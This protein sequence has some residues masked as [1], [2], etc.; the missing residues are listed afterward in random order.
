M[1]IF[2]LQMA[3]PC[4]LTCPAFAVH[5]QCNRELLTVQ[6]TPTEYL[7][8]QGLVALAMV[9]PTSPEIISELATCKLHNADTVASIL[10]V[11]VFGKC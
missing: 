11:K 3:F 2:I 8:N 1:Q 9:L 6:L 7:S 10:Q 4:D 5:M